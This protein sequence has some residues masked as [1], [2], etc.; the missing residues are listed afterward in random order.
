MRNRQALFAQ[1]AHQTEGDQIARRDDRDRLSGQVLFTQERGALGPGLG[2]LQGTE[3]VQGWRDGLLQAGPGGTNVPG[4]GLAGRGCVA[5]QSAAVVSGL[6]EMPHDLLGGGC[7]VETAGD[8]ARIR[9]GETDLHHGPAGDEQ[10]V[11]P[12]AEIG[13]ADHNQGIRSVVLE[14]ADLVG[15]LPGIAFHACHQQGA[16]R[17]E[18]TAVEL[19]QNCGEVGIVERPHD[20]AN[21]FAGAAEQHAGGRVGSVA[22]GI[23]ERGHALGGLGGDAEFLGAAIEYAGHHG[24]AD[25]GAF[26]DLVLAGHGSPGVRRRRSPEF[27][28]SCRRAVKRARRR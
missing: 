28:Q 17:R 21:Q 10:I 22:E 25:A 18:R 14:E 8:H 4:A 3:Q 24:L 23:G 13:G 6:I 26:R 7:L 19:L 20:H 16:A 27:G 5:D 9:G 11:G 15:A 2:T 12:L 1:F